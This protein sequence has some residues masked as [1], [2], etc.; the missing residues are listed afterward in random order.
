LV[1]R[2][3][4]KIFDQ[5]FQLDTLKSTVAYF[6]N[7]WGVKVS[8]MM[9]STAYLEEPT[10]IPGLKEA[11]ATLDVSD[12]PARIASATEFIL[13]GLHLHQKLNKEREGGRYTYRA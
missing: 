10:H 1:N 13:E 8:D 3:V 12:Q 9:T 7:G 4:L 11:L 6:S 2:A 5:H